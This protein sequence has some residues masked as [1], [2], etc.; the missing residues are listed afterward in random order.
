VGVALCPEVE[1]NSSL[2]QNF[3]LNWRRV[4]ESNEITPNNLTES[5]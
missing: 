4:L 5:Q 2:N 3:Y 1:V